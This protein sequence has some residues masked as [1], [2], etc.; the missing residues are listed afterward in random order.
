[1]NALDLHE[2]LI[3]AHDRQHNILNEADARAKNL[4]ENKENRA[5][6]TSEWEEEHEEEAIR[7]LRAEAKELVFKIN[8][9][10]AMLRATQVNEDVER[11]R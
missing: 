3:V 2:K 6:F 5:S 4:K 8:G 10:R 11:G 1:M 7:E 9:I